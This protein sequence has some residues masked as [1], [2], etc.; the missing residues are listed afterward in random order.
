MTTIY[1][2]LLSGK[3][4]HAGF[5]CRPCKGNGIDESLFFVDEPHSCKSCAGVGYVSKETAIEQADEYWDHA[6]LLVEC[7]LLPSEAG[8]ETRDELR[9]FYAYVGVKAPWNR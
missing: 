1:D 6:S 9:P 4:P 8:K 7:N 2:T 3:P 5:V